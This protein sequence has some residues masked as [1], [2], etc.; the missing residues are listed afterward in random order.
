[1]CVAQAS[2]DLHIVMQSGVH[3]PDG[4]GDL[5]AFNGPSINNAGQLAFVSQLTGTAGGT[6]DNTAMFRRDSNGDLAVIARSGSTFSGKPILTFFP[7]SAYL[8]ADGT[9]GSVLGFAGGSLA[10][11]LGS[12]GPLTQIFP[13]AMPSPSGQS[14][15]LLGVTSAVINDSGYLVYRAVFN[16]AQ[17]ESGLYQRAPDG[18]QSVRLLSNTTAPRGGTITS[19]GGFPTLNES[20]QVGTILSINTGAPSSIKSAARIDGTTVHELVRQGDLL[21]D[22]VTTVGAFLSTSGFINSTG[23]V[24]FAANLTQPSFGGQG[25]FLADDSGASVVA[26]G[27]LPGFTSAATDITVVGISN[28]SRVAFTA[29]ATAGTDPLSGIYR[30][31]PAD[32]PSLPSKTQQRP[33]QANSFAAF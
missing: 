27:V 24:A 29:N 12:G 32:R 23:Q 18:T 25:V 30:T 16:G 7:G 6:A 31:G 22:G 5:S 14:N 13:T 17:P 15:T 8:S 4:N 10:Y 2:A 19:P 21:A 33:S 3:S 26:K 1:M 28:A 20:N 9:V 11:T